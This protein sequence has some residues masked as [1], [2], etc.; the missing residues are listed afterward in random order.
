MG[1][2]G[3]MTRARLILDRW[4]VPVTVATAFALA[5]TGGS[6]LPYTGALPGPALGTTWVLYALRALVIF[7]GLLLLVI[8]LLRALRGELPVE[9]SVRGARYEEAGVTRT[10][11]DALGAEVG[12]IWIE[13]E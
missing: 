11:L 5:V 10:A 6:L 1:Q 2:F 13:L 8:P 9:L 3:S 7:Y 12:A 4:A